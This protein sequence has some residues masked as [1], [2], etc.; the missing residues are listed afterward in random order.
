M[1]V[2][3]SRPSRLLGAGFSKVLRNS[4]TIKMVLGIVLFFAGMS[5]LYVNHRLGL[6]LAGAGLVL[7]FV[8]AEFLFGLCID[9]KGHK[10]TRSRSNSTKSDSQL[11]DVTVKTDKTGSVTVVTAAETVASDVLT[12]DDQLS[13]SPDI[14]ETMSTSRYF[15]R[16]VSP[17]ATSSPREDPMFHR[18]RSAVLRLQDGDGDAVKGVKTVVLKGQCNQ[19]TDQACKFHRTRSAVIRSEEV[20]KATAAQIVRFNLGTDADDPPDSPARQTTAGPGKP[21]SASIPSGPSAA[22]SGSESGAVLA[23]G[24]SVDASQQFNFHRSKS[25][26]MHRSSVSNEEASS[27]KSSPTRTAKATSQSAN[28]SPYRER[29]TVTYTTTARVQQIQQM[30]Q[31]Q[32]PAPRG[33]RAWGSD[34]RPGVATQVQQEPTMVKTSFSDLSN[35]HYTRFHRIR[36]AAQL[37]QAAATATSNPALTNRKKEQ[38]TVTPT[39]LTRW[40]LSSAS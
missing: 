26:V 33:G 9:F 27:T 34:G 7:V 20:A 4:I 14:F 21:K 3:H 17:P 12:E 2:L 13:S 15:T 23:R 1:L 18:T 16:K 35:E 38:L 10:E 28:T 24:A 6:S 22:R 37:Q 31:Q 32:V 39:T 11:T 36:A 29:S 8:P 30:Q 40:E 25:A 19:R 5:S